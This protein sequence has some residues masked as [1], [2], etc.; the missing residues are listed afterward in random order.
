VPVASKLDPNLLDT[1][2]GEPLALSVP[3]VSPHNDRRAATIFVFTSEANDEKEPN[4]G[5]MK[6]EEE[7]KTRTG[8]RVLAVARRACKVACVPQQPRTT[9]RCFK[10]EIVCTRTTT[11]QREGSVC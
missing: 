5:A 11:T 2:V 1:A 6:R 4:V 8:Y 9:R 10:F 3:A 7:G